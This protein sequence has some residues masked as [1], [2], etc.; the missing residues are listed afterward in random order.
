MKIKPPA[1]GRKKIPKKITPSY[2]HNAGLYYLQRYAASAAQFRKVLVRKAQRSCAHH[3]D[4]DLE[5][6]RAMI[7][8]IVQKF[9]QSG[10]LNDD[11]YL[12]GMVI[13]LRRQ[14]RSKSM[15]VQ[16]LM[17]KGLSAAAIES[18][19]HAADEEQNADLDGEYRAALLF[20]RK[21]KLG[22]NTEPQHQMK[23]LQKMARAGFSYDIA[24]K[25][26]RTENL[27][28]LHG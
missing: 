13:T 3:K 12:R 21:K 10:L 1:S 28:E 24:R 6:C 5:A 22:L 20:A 15:I 14:G 8:E 7:E 4:Q 9:L 18:A 23:D 25:V 2:L 17:H 19:L 26:L 27:E 16:K 11:L